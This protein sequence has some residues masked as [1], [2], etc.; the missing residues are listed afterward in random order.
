MTEVDNV[1]QE[2]QEWFVLWKLQATTSMHDDMQ[3]VIDATATMFLAVHATRY[4]KYVRLF[5]VD[6]NDSGWVSDITWNMCQWLG[7]TYHERG[8]L[9]S[10]GGYSP[11]THVNNLIKLQAERDGIPWCGGLRAVSFA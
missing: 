3:R 4:T 10:G 8:L 6:H 11:A 9:C 2:R 7:I 5:L 1:E